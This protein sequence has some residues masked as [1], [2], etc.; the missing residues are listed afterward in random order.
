MLGYGENGFG[1]V[2]STDYHD[3]DGDGFVDDEFEDADFD[4]FP[5]DVPVWE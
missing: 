4:P 3:K 2:D 5:P 1:G